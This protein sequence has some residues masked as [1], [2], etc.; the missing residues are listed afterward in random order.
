LL[1][2][3]HYGIETSHP[4]L[5]YTK[6]FWL[7]SNHYGIETW[8]SIHQELPLRIVAI[9]PLW[10]W[11]PSASATT[12]HNTNLV[13][14]E[15]LWYWNAQ[16]RL[17]S[18]PNYPGC[19]RTIMVLKQYQRKKLELQVLVAIEPL[20][21][22]NSRKLPHP[23]SRHPVAIEPLWYWNEDFE[24]GDLCLGGSCNRTIMVLKLN[25]SMLT[26]SWISTLQS[27]HYGIETTTTSSLLKH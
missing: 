23:L 3:N 21:Y 11:N 19:N 17:P 26:H 13:A 6:E 7:Q 1:Q 5:A 22:W 16:F 14:I 25:S 8:T 27:N 12:C 15:P 20:W 18:E 9:E 24:P 10:Y 4:I 2:S